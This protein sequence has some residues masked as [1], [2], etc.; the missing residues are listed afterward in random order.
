NQLEDEL[1]SW[2]FTP[3][4]SADDC[5]RCAYIMVTRAAQQAGVALDRDGVRK[6]LLAVR[7]SYHSSNAFHNFEHAV[8]VTQATYYMLHKAGVLHSSR[9]TYNENKEEKSTALPCK[10]I[11]KS[12]DAFALVIACL[13]HDLGHQGLSNVFMTNAGT[14][15]AHLFN[16][17]SV[18]ENFHA[19]SMFMLFSNNSNN[20][21]SGSSNGNTQFDYSHFRA[22]ASSSVLATD[23]SRH[24]DYLNRFAKMRNDIDNGYLSCEKIKLS[25]RQTICAALIKC[26]DLVNTSRDFS[27]AAQWTERFVV[28]SLIL[29]NIEESLNLPL[30]MPGLPDKTAQIQHFFYEKL[31]L[32]MYEKVADLIPELQYCVDN[33]KLNVLKW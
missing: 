2:S 9:F 20:N 17:Q 13:G 27:V 12:I 25:D 28:E 7:G 33:V 19:L 4:R 22:I 24:S 16:D 26:S 31:A 23:M 15:L 14:S 6:F 11:L 1:L 5:L 21:S 29:T 8:D 18:L 30:T 10:D 3:F 32:P